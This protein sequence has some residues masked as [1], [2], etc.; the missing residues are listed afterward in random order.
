[1]ELKVTFTKQTISLNSL[2]Y[3]EDQEYYNACYYVFK[4]DISDEERDELDSDDR[5][6]I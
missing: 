4:K 6:N 5:D 3:N 1:M 2:Q